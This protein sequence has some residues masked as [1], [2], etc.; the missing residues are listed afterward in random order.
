MIKMFLSTASQA[1][2]RALNWGSGRKD[3]AHD[4]CLIPYD[5]D[6]LYISYPF[7]VNLFANLCLCSIHVDF[8]PLDT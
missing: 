2:C 5:G 8:L 3:D 1:T 6:E 7:E 4:Q